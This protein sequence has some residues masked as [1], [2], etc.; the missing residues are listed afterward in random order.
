MSVNLVL[1]HVLNGMTHVLGIVVW[2]FFRG[3]SNVSIAIT[4]T[5]KYIFTV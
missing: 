4:N 5:T 3:H 1:V 2:Y